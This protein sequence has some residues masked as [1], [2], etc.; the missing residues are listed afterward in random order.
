[1]NVLKIFK[2]CQAITV[3][4]SESLR[5]EIK[6][7]KIIRGHQAFANDQ[8]GRINCNVQAG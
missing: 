5:L 8:T 4:L 1:M 3:T 2:K 7:Q 6:E